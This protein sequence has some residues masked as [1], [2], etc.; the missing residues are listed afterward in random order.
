M[1]LQARGVYE[2]KDRHKLVDI[3]LRHDSPTASA[4]RRTFPQRPPDASTQASRAPGGGDVLLDSSSSAPMAIHTTHVAAPAHSPRAAQQSGLP[5]VQTLWDLGNQADVHV[6]TAATA[7]VA[8]VSC[9]LAELAAIMGTALGSSSS[10]GSQRRISVASML[11]RQPQLLHT[12]LSALTDRVLYL[13]INLSGRLDVAKLLEQQP[14]L[15]LQESGT[16]R[17]AS[18]PCAAMPASHGLVGDPGRR[19]IQYSS[20]AGP[21]FRM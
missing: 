17:C 14:S 11:M 10:S 15:L 9:R 6:H 12:D 1:L 18:C 4:R 16:A 7:L 19:H 13:H 20:F 5:G 2:R 8:H 21:I 3:A